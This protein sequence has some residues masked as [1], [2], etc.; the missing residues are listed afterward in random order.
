MNEDE[1]K[2]ALNLFEQ[3]MAVPNKAVFT[4]IPERCSFCAHQA[5][6]DGKTTRIGWANMCLAHFIQVGIGIGLGKGQVLICKKPEKSCG[7]CTHP[8]GG[9]CYNCSG[10]NFGHAT[11]ISNKGLCLNWSQM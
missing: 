8:D 4:A 11:E 1:I 7:N 9:V 10:E 3:G 6:V 5:L 2:E